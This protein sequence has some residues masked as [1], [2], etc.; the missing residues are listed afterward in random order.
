MKVYL[1]NIIFSIQKSGGISVYWYEMIS[2]IIGQ[3]DMEYTF[4]EENNSCKNIFRNELD[5][6]EINFYDHKNRRRKF[7]S[8]YRA[9]EIKTEDSA[10]IFHSSYY[11][12]LSKKLKKRNNIKEVVT[13]HDFTYEHFNRGIKRWVHSAQKK[14]AIQQA[15][16]VICISENTKKDLLNFF[17]EFSHKDI[18]VIYNGVS[19]DY[20]VIPNLK[21]EK[22]IAPYFLFVGSRAIYKNFDFAIMAIA[23]LE[24]SIVKIV[25]FNLN[26]EELELLNGLM[27][28]RWELFVN[29][30]NAKLNELYNE[31]YALIYPSSYEGFGIPI[32]EAMKC[33]CPFIALNSSSIPEVAGDAGVLIGKLDLSLFNQAIITI[34]NNRGEIVKKGFKQAEKFSWEKC[35]QEIVDVYKD[36]Y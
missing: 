26:K 12:T 19:T 29:I 13:V 32:V 1:D 25:G 18:R 17:P 2:R 5:I 20:H 23:Q 15:E 3:K 35:Y 14:K 24:N 16:V 11:R 34:D 27:P 8:R 6:G 22:L 10:F 21:T 7:L 33:G 31:A 28:G 36:L 30:E 4:I 9:I